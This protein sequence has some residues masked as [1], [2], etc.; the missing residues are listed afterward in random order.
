M[1][2]IVEIIPMRRDRNLLRLHVLDGLAI[3]D[4]GALHGVHRATA[5]R[6]IERTREDVARAVRRDL[7]RQ[8]GI[9]PFEVDDLLRW[10]QSQ[11]DL[12]LSGLA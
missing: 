9:D 5:A 2:I 7:M 6:W 12:S 3:D 11:I 10:V 1:V 4:I 8:L